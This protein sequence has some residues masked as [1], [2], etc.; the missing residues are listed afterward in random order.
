MDGEQE[1]GKNCES[2]WLRAGRF[3]G[4]ILVFGSLVGIFGL[5]A[6]DLPNFLALISSVVLVGT[7]QYQIS[8]KRHLTCIEQ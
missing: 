4:L 2:A 5:Q 6:F 8:R 3:I 1:N 7:C